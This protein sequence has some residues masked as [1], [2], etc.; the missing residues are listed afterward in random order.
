MKIDVKVRI[1]MGLL[2]LSSRITKKKKF[3][4]FCENSRRMMK[5]M[6]GEYD[7]DVDVCLFRGDRKSVV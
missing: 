4:L 7:D 1:V 3:Q 2:S 5:I 6:N